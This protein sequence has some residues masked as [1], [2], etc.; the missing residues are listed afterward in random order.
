MSRIIKF[1]VWTG[2]EMLSL[3]DFSTANYV[4]LG[5]TWEARRRDDSVICTQATPGA[6]LL[7][8]T[9]L[10]DKDGNEIYEGDIVTAKYKGSFTG[11]VVSYRGAFFIRT[12]NQACAEPYIRLDEW[13]E[14]T[15][16]IKTTT[17]LGNIYENPE[18]LPS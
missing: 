7:Q 2:S 6:A 18:L 16:S 3:A 8:F 14:V 1:R 4:S 10:T 12:P 5:L 13:A 15:N 17:I 11:R 9:G